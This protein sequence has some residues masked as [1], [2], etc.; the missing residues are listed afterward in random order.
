VTQQE[1]I[2]PASRAV[3]SLRNSL[4][5]TQQAFAVEFVKTA[6]TTVARWETSHPPRGRTLIRLAEV[7]DQAGFTGLGE[8]FRFLYAKEAIA[9]LKTP[10]FVH[11][12]SES[13]TDEPRGYAIFRFDDSF[14]ISSAINILAKLLPNQS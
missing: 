4:G 8:E 13:Q 6:V 7:A 1:K 14:H 2:H 12:T 3:V 10:A 11:V 9:S 5:K